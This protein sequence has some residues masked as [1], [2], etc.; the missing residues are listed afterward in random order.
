MVWQVASTTASAAVTDQEVIAAPGVRKQIVVYSAHLSSDVKET[1]TFHSGGSTE[2][3]RTY[4]GADNPEDF[5]SEHPVFRCL[6]NESLTL[7]TNQP[8][9]TFISVTYRI[10]PDFAG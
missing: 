6:P 4:L 10:E 7:T 9:E 3:W 8:G 5:S 2:V 1:V